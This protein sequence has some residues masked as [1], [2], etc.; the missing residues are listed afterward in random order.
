MGTQQNENTVDGSE[1]GSGNEH[2]EH[3]HHLVGALNWRTLRGPVVDLSPG[4][5]EGATLSVLDVVPLGLFEPSVYVSAGHVPMSS[6]SPSLCSPFS[7]NSSFASIKF[8]GPKRSRVLATFLKALSA[9]TL[10]SAKSVASNRGPSR[11][12]RESC[13][14][15][16]LAHDR[17]PPYPFLRLSNSFP[18]LSSSISLPELLKFPQ[19]SFTNSR[20]LHTRTLYCR[21]TR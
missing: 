6:T 15:T 13:G 7:S 11:F 20:S 4:K 21:G 5:I 2:K 12:A 14:L 19:F 16:L 10:I 1:V 17:G 18:S 3:N 9:K 8:P